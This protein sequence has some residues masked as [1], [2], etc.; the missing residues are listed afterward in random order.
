MELKLYN[1][2][3][4]ELLGDFAQ[5][6]ERHE[7]HVRDF[8][9]GL[10]LKPSSYNTYLARLSGFFSWCSEQGY[11]QHVPT[12]AIRQQCNGGDIDQE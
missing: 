11:I 6:A 7:G 5:R 3:K 9:Q 1:R 12:A 8:L 4:H 10:N 2:L